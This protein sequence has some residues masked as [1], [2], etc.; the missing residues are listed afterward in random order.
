MWIIPPRIGMPIKFAIANQ[1]VP[2]TGVNSRVSA[3]R[4]TRH[5]A[6]LTCKFVTVLFGG[7]NFIEETIGPPKND[8]I[9][10]GTCTSGI[11]SSGISVLDLSRPAAFLRLGGAELT[12]FPSYR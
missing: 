9:Q 11:A 7:R 6:E 10:E 3:V 12:F 8:S 4:S 2:D 5:P 1:A